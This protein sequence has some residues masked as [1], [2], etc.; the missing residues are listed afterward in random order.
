VQLLQVIPALSMGGAEKVMVALTRAAREAGHE[1]AVAAG[2]GPLADELES[3]AFALPVVNRQ[4]RRLPAAARALR[5]A[6]RTFRPDVVHAHGPTMGLLTALISAR[7]RDP[8][9]LVSMHGVPDED[10]NRAALTLRLAGLPIVACGPG[11]SAALVERGLR[12]KATIVNGIAPP[13]APADRR[14]V[15]LELGVRSGSP[16][17]VSVGRLVDQKNHGLAIEALGLVPEASLV[18]FGEGP[19]RDALG[20]QAAALGVENRVVFAGLRTDVRAIVGAADALVMPSVWEGLPL[21]ALEA[22]AAG[23]PVVAT[24]VRGI[25]ELV[26]NEENCLLV[27][28]G[29]AQ[30]LAA[31]L[32]RVLGDHGLRDR[33]SEAGLVLARS[34]SED[35]MVTPFLELYE[36][37]AEDSHRNGRG[38]ARAR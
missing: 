31:A 25:Q 29:D 21:V 26:T 37:L 38:H 27:P 24:A 32:T 36:N 28:P 23:T 6:I 15:E 3:E 5:I 20:K 18:I 22:L 30:A 13:P 19:L 16:L 33:L 7:G 12:L 2:P 4:L 35:A 11:V 34:Y 8:R 14:S 10:Y 1:V 9:A 17:L